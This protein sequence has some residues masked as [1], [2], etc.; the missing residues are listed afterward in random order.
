MTEISPRA[1]IDERTYLKMYPNTTI[2]DYVVVSARQ[3]IMMPGA[4]INAGAK[5]IGERS[6]FLGMG[7]VVSYN[8]VLLTSTDQPSANMCQNAPEEVRSIRH[9]NIVIGNNAFIGANAVVFPGVTINNGAV[10]GVGVVV[11]EDVEPWT[12]V[13]LDYTNLMKSQRKMRV[14]PWAPLNLGG[15]KLDE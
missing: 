10:I 11:K 7:S 4:H 1:L 9:G 3:L 5:L 6:I 8:A 2:G 12:V 13:K 14:S 15:S